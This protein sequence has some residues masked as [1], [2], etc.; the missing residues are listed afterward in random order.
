MSDRPIRKSPPRSGAADRTEGRDPALIYSDAPAH[1][2]VPF[3]S[4]KNDNTTEK[5]K[6]SARPGRI[7]SLAL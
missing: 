3:A 2:A 5:R 4:E 6:S 1:A 7:G